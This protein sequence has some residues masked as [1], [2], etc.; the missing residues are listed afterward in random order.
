MSPGMSPELT[1]HPGEHETASWK[2]EQNFILP[3]QRLPKRL[4]WPSVYR[5]RY[6]LTHS[7][8]KEQMHTS[9]DSQW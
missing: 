5:D 9:L 3:G 2:N 6:A 7:L 8:Y 4:C 1:P